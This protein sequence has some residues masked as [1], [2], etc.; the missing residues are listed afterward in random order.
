MD[1]FIRARIEIRDEALAKVEAVFKRFEINEAS[2]D[3]L[4]AAL[5]TL[6][7]AQQLCFH[8]WL[9]PSIETLEDAAEATLDP[10]ERGNLATAGTSLI[11]ESVYESARRQRGKKGRG[12]HKMEAA[13]SLIRR[14]Q[15]IYERSTSQKAT[16]SSANRDSKVDRVAL[17]GPYPAFLRRAFAV[18]KPIPRGDIRWP[19]DPASLAKEM[20]R[21]SRRK[22]P[23]KIYPVHAIT[24][25]SLG[26]MTRKL[27]V[28]ELHR[29][30]Q[31]RGTVSRRKPSV[32]SANWLHVA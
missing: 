16:I 5:V 29:F 9:A 30:A 17:Y 19:S 3:E 8:L 14:L 12:P 23:A 15:H 18:F 6:F 11:I 21:K 22:P 28:T 32:A 13:R 2:D 4:L 20:G 25:K 31:L 27:S 1:E 26:D 24:R 10:I 7:K